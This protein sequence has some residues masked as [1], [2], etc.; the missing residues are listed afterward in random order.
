MYTSSTLTL[1]LFSMRDLQYYY[2][3]QTQ[4]WMS[5]DSNTKNWSVV[6]GASA[7]TPAATAAQ[8]S[9]SNA[10][11]AATAAAGTSAGA[12]AAGT[13]AATTTTTS[14]AAPP[15]AAEK[16]LEKVNLAK[17]IQKVRLVLHESI[18]CSSIRISESP[19]VQL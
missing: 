13:T 9:D 15:T 16:K 1:T 11:Q 2:S 18:A 7:S 10:A 3:P 6:S 8:T 14:T 4:Q 17:K 19:C 5:Y 12:T